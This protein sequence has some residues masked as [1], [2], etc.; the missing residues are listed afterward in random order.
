[1]QPQKVDFVS[2]PTRDLDRAAT[3]YG[4]TIGLARD[5]LSISTWPEFTAGNVTLAVAVPE[6]I[7]MEFAPLP[8]GAIAIRVPDVADARTELE[9]HGV[10]FEGDTFDS[11]ACHMAFFR[12]PDGNGLML[13]HRYEPYHDGTMP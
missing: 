8:I 5:P 9:Q 12:D 6:Q 11:G 2:I 13:H 10:A 7:D 3:F 4:E 1:M